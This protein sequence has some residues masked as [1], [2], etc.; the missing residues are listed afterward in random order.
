MYVDDFRTFQRFFFYLRI[1]S[2]NE[3]EKSMIKLKNKDVV[4]GRCTHK[5]MQ[6]IVNFLYGKVLNGTVRNPSY[7]ESIAVHNFAENEL[8]KIYDSLSR[9]YPQNATTAY[10]EI[11]RC[12]KA[13]VSWLCNYQGIIGG[14]NFNFVL[15]NYAAEFKIENGVI[16]LLFEFS[17]HS[18]V[19][20]DWKTGKAKDSDY[21]Q[22]YQYAYYLLKSH[23][24]VSRF[25]ILPVYLKGVACTSNFAFAPNDK[26]KKFKA[27]DEIMA[28]ARSHENLL[29]GVPSDREPEA[30]YKLPDNQR[31][32]NHGKCALCKKCDCL[33]FDLYVQEE[34]QKV[35]KASLARGHKTVED[36]AK[37]NAIDDLTRKH[38]ENAKNI[39]SDAIQAGKSFQGYETSYG[40][41][42]FAKGQKEKAKEISIKMGKISYE[43]FDLKA[44]GKIREADSELYNTLISAG[45]ITTN[46][47][48]IIKHDKINK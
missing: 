38:N 34:R 3:E 22:L 2:Q 39:I 29:H 24:T 18:I 23:M 21:D 37:L 11:E 32:P 4:V 8:V 14:K 10:H 33:S 30:C 25:V 13:G 16:D 15:I 1:Y 12:V 44:P 9:E 26:S 31:K 40:G 28:W 42:K 43:L 41:M 45:C 27:P 7:E 6:A 5:A 47:R 36:L 35:I 19:I 48:I 46:L 20:L 17:D